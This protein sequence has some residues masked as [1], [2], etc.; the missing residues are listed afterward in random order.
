ML[1]GLK[2]TA[3][4]Y[5]PSILSW[6]GGTPFVRTLSKTPQPIFGLI[7][8]K[9]IKM[10][11]IQ[12]SF[13]AIGRPA[14]DGSKRDEYQMN[15][16]I[17]MKQENIFWLVARAL[18]VQNGKQNLWCFKFVVKNGMV[19]SHFNQ[20][21]LRGNDWSLNMLQKQVFDSLQLTFRFARNLLSVFLWSKPNHSESCK[22]RQ[23]I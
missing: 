5:F 22:L 1:R 3:F 8:C 16:A 15:L 4:R 21:E 17:L 11:H 14:H 2:K 9:R 19:P 13:W 7:R 20:L 23:K 18:A 12:R 10:T 6:T